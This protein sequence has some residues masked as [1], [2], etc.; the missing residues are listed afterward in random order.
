MIFYGSPV[1][2]FFCLLE[3]VYG[4]NGLRGGRRFCAFHV[5]GI[6]YHLLTA[7]LLM[8]RLVDMLHISRTSI[9]I[10]NL[11]HFYWDS[12]MHLGVSSCFLIHF[13]VI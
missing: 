10:M 7:N 8:S 6:F 9:E 3:P 13:R 12:A 2:I 1:A 11:I 4:W 5:D